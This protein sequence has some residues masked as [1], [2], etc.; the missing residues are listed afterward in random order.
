MET[1]VVNMAKTSSPSSPLKALYYDLNIGLVANNC[2]GDIIDDFV[3][4]T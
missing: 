3:Q 4:E 2:S 1:I